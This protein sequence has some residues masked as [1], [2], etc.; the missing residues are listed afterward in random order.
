MKMIQDMNTS[1]D[2]IEPE[3]SSDRNG[4]SERFQWSEGE[5]AP[6]LRT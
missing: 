4:E 3:L 5:M 1:P 6:L 2:P